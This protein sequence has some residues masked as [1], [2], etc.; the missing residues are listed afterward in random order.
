M[1][2]ISTLVEYLRTGLSIRT[3]LNS[4]RMARITTTNAWFFGFL[5]FLLKLFGI[6]DSVFEITKKEQSSSNEGAKENNGK[7]TFNNSQIFVPGTT[8]L[9]IQIT[10][11]VTKLLGWQAPV[12][13][14]H[15]SG[16]GELFCCSYLVVCYWPFFKGLFGKGKYGIPLSTI[17]KSVV[18]TLLF[19]YFCRAYQ[20]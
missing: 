1:Y 19:L 5:H 15:R 9:L 17:C 20:G 18:L 4:E 12:R 6:S 7:F 8:I 14:G 13:N 16:I 11:L 10:A 2:N 3:W